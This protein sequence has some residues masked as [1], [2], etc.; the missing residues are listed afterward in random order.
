MQQ[1][2]KSFGWDELYP[3]T[4]ER[5]LFFKQGFRECFSQDEISDNDLEEA[6]AYAFVMYDQGMVYGIYS[7]LKRELVN[8]RAIG[9]VVSNFVNAFKATLSETTVAA[10]KPE[11]YIDLFIQMLYSFV[12]KPEFTVSSITLN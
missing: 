7:K 6:V 5:L 2:L 11:H 4:V 8:G 9:E 10:I 3:D 1:I 12:I